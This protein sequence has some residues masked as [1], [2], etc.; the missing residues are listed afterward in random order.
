MPI[1][2]KISWGQVAKK[3]MSFP[4]AILGVTRVEIPNME[5]TIALKISNYVK[6]MVN[7]HSKLF[8]GAIYFWFLSVSFGLEKGQWWNIVGYGAQ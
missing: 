3:S 4:T 5:K 2:I 1:K 6:L 7:P 8:V